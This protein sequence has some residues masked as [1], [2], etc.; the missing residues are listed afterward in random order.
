MAIMKCN[1]KHP[2]QDKKHGKGNRVHNKAANAAYDYRC[3]VCEKER[4]K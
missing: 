3:T 4:S 2:Y 1:C